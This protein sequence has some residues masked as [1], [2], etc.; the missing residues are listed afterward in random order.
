M[1]FHLAITGTVRTIAAEI[2]NYNNPRGLSCKGVNTR[3]PF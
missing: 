1:I 3:A 2:N